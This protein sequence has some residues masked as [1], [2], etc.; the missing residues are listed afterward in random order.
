LLFRPARPSRSLATRDSWA[1]FIRATSG[2]WILVSTAIGFSGSI[3]CMIRSRKMNVCAM[4]AATLGADHQEQR[5]FHCS[6]PLPDRTNL[7]AASHLSA[8]SAEAARSTN[9][10]QM[11]RFSSQCGASDISC[12][13]AG[14]ELAGATVDF[15]AIRNAH[16]RIKLFLSATNTCELERSAFLTTTRSDPTLF[17]PRLVYRFCS[18]DRN[19]R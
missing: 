14:S 8:I 6:M 11:Q 16:C 9:H 15:G 13:Q 5:P 12:C 18:S 7:R 2:F 10:A 19:R 17:W 1:G 3:R 4:A